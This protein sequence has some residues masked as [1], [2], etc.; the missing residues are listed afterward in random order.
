[1]AKLYAWTDGAC[2]GNPGPGGWGV[3][4]RA[5]DGE[6]VVKERELKGGEAETTNNRMELLAAINALE[7]LTRDTAITI[8]TDS[9]YVKNGVTGWI[10]GWKRNGWKTA[11]KKP[12]KNVDLWQRLDEAQ[13]R[14]R[15]TWEWIKGHAG[16]PENER[17]DE[18]ARAGMEP[19]K[20]AKQK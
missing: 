4:M 2:S 12:V 19:F 6:A 5:M 17:A 7:A 16:H 20:P 3:L 13:R 15:V 10:H 11:A 1:M 8:T 14:H 9:A 18:L